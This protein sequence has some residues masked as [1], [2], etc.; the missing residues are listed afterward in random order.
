MNKAMMLGAARYV[1]ADN[2]LENLEE[3][4]RYG[5]RPFVLHGRKAFEAVETG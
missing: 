3:L 2:A 5:R 1:R 4:K